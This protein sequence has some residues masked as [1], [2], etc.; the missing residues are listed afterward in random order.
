MFVSVLDFFFFSSRRR[1]TRSL[2]D[3]SSDVCSSDLHAQ[4]ALEHFRGTGDWRGLAEANFGIALAEVYEGD[5]EPALEHFQQALKLIGDHPA[6]Y[7]LGK[8]YTNMAGACW[9]LKRPQEGIGYLEKAIG[10]YERTEHKANATDGYNN[11]GNN[12]ILVGDWKRAQDALERALALASEIDA[13]GPRVPMVLDSLGELR[14]LRGD[15]HEAQVYLERAV[16]LAREHGNKWYVW[17]PL[18][19]LGRCYLLMNAAL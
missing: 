9:F 3:W 8:I 16:R 15:L 14:M 12:L 5:Y 13:N 18:R 1:H 10:Y 2:C 11:L 19:T 17:Q 6:P 4:K 7:L